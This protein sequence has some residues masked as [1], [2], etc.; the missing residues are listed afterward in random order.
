MMCLAKDAKDRP[1]HARE[2]AELYEQAMRNG[3][4]L[5]GPPE[6][7][8]GELE[9]EP[10]IEE[11]VT[12]DPNAMVFHMD[13]WMPEKIA[14]M[15]MRGFV[16][17]VG[18]DV[19]ESIPGRIRMRLNGL[20]PAGGPLS[21]LGIRRNRSMDVEL[22][23]NQPDPRKENQLKITV[24]FHAPDARTARDAAW[25]KRCGQLFIEVRA[26]LMGI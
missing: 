9:E 5:F 4:Y 23:L 18:G 7:E 20:A 22:L 25:R 15:K 21:W 26:Y 24:L 19:V 3:D 16:H 10:A 14:I 6:G 13:A 8:G 2:L 1:Q 12:T 11:P 17:D